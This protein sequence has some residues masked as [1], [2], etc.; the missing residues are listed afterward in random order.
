[1]T[2]L[3]AQQ[4]LARDI[5][6]E[7]IEIDT[8]DSSGDTTEAA[9]AVARRLRAAG[10]SEGD[11]QV[12]GPH[13]RKGNLVARLRGSGERKPLLLLAH[14]DVVEAQRDEWSVDPFTFLERDGYF[15]GRGT[16]DDKAMAAIWVANQIRRKQ[17]GFTPDRDIILALTADEEG[18]EHNGAKWLLQDHRELVEAE[19]GLNEG[20][21]GRLK[22]GKRISNTVQASEKVY[23]D[24]QL[25]AKGRSGHSSL[26]SDDNAITHLAEALSRLAR[27]QFPVKLTEVTRAFFQRMAEIET[28]LVAEDM[29]SILRTPPDPEALA[30]L[31]AVPYYQGLMRTTCVATRLDAGHSNNTV[32]ALAHAVVNCRLLPGESPYEVRQVLTQ[33]IADGRVAV[34]PL[35]AAKPSP[36]SPLTP[37]VMEPIERITEEMWPGVPVVPIMGIGATDSL[38]FRQAG[39]PVYGVSGIFL[40]VDDVRAHGRDERIN[41]QAFY[42]GQEF[43]YRLVRALSG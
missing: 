35:R 29:R 3:C 26:P 43:L 7:L 22:D 37:E 11:V 28:G 34:R 20:G 41:V 33:V 1:M 13:P 31:S 4:Q 6:R 9:Q 38:Y 14:L 27:H 12:L 23:L 17:E 32:P 8:T 30:R 2:S 16:T 5:F 21:Y 39:I 19:Y 36:P 10:F 25:E 24:F 18:G 40:D 15:Y 42:E